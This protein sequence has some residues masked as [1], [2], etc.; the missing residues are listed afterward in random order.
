MQVV[1]SVTSDRFNGHHSGEGT[2][3]LHIYLQNNGN[4]HKKMTLKIVLKIFKKINYQFLL[5]PLTMSGHG[6]AG[7][8]FSLFY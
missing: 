4:R 6:L 8:M 1:N 5:S 2:S 7:H 3:I